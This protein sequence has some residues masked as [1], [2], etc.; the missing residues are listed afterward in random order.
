M[1]KPKMIVFDYG[2]TLCDHLYIRDWLEL[3]EVLDKL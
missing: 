1:T 3:L 2:H